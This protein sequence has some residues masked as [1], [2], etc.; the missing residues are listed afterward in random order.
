M[1]VGEDRVA[2]PLGVR[3]VHAVI[4]G[5]IVVELSGAQAAIQCRQHSKTFITCNPY[6]ACVIAISKC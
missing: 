5:V 2:A 3:Q 4:A 6:V 1:I